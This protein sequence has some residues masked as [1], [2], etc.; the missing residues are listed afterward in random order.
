LKA[1]PEIS[2]TEAAPGGIIN[3]GCGR[4]YTRGRDRT[5][6]QREDGRWEMRD[7]EERKLNLEG[8]V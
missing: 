8:Y 3:R 5:I 1:S 7:S 2:H 6:K 4:G